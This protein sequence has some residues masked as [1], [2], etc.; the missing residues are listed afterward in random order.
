MASEEQRLQAVAFDAYGTLFDVFSIGALAEDLFPG[1]GKIIAQVWRDKQIEYT[2]LRTLCGRYEN[3][4]QCTQDALRFVD[5]ALQ[6]DMSSA[7][8]DDLLDAYRRLKP[9]NENVRALERLRAMGLKL[10][11]LSNGNLDML[12]TVVGAAAMTSHFDYLLSV[13]SVRKF[14]TAPEAYQLAPDAFGC[15]ARQILFASSNGWDIAGATWF[16]FTTFWVNRSA[17]PAEELIPPHAEGRSLDDLV[18]FAANR[19]P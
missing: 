3:F 6:L 17:Q 14:K 18:R 8:R 10:A 9:F 12:E 7:Q 2:R 11:I 13:D 16:G 5:R 15:S 19:V 4:W 1:K